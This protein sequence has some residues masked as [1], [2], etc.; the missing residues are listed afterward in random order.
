MDSLIERV[1][2]GQNKRVTA[3]LQPPLSS[4]GF[5]S[6]SLAPR[7]GKAKTLQAFVVRIVYSLSA[8]YGDSDGRVAEV[9][10]EYSE[11]MYVL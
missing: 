3:S 5:L 8:Y 7:G 1:E 6:P 9:K 2:I 4:F 10:S 11:R